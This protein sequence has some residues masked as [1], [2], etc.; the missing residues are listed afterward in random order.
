MIKFIERF[1]IGRKGYIIQELGGK[2]LTK[3]ISSIHGVFHKC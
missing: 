1:K 3:T 2:S